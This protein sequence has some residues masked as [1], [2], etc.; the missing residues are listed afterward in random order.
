M[1]TKTIKTKA[2]QS[3]EDKQYCEICGTYTLPKRGKRCTNA[4]HERNRE[5]KRQRVRVRLK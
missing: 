3:D 4:N 1:N 5:F 2:I